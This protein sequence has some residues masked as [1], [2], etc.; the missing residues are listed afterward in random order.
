[1]MGGDADYSQSVTQQDKLGFWEPNAGIRTGY[2]VKD[3]TLDGQI[4]NRDKNQTW[5]ITVG[6]ETEVPE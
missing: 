6:A 4:D 2:D 3:F 1:M 5:A